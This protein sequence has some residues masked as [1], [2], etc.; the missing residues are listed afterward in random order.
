MDR[1]CREQKPSK[2][3]SSTWP[4]FATTQNCSLL[5][6]TGCLHYSPQSS[7]SSVPA[8]GP[9]SQSCS[10]WTVN[11]YCSFLSRFHPTPQ[12][13]QPFSYLHSYV[14]L[15]WTPWQRLRTPLL[16]KVSGGTA[17]GLQPGPAELWF[18]ALHLCIVQPLPELCCFLRG[19]AMKV[20]WAWY[21]RRHF[22]KS[23][24][25]ATYSEVIIFRAMLR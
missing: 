17:S 6:L 1:Q 24:V 20:L 10:S 5:H 11:Q 15:A 2:H 21:T 13:T 16:P 12:C 19:I 22:S 18:R 4:L 23:Q 25:T 9:Q 7:W 14:L 3:N 8:H